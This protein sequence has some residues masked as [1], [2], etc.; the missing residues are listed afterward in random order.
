V[1]AVAAC[2]D[3]GTRSAYSDMGDAIWCA[4]PSNDGEPALTPGIWTTDRTGHAGYNPGSLSQGDAS[5]NYTNSF[6]GTSSAC[7]GM[8]GVAALMLSANP[9]LTAAEVK[10]IVREGCDRIDDVPGEYDADGHSAKYGYGRVNAA[11]VVQA[12]LDRRTTT[13][14]SEGPVVIPG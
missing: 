13:A 1:I 9:D 7:P 10:A 12:A 5:G 11:A 4:F 14:G 6:G 2:N 8:A 3:S